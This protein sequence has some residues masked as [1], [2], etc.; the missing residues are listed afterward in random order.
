MSIRT[1][2]W[3]G[4]IPC[5]ADLSV[6]D[7][8]AAQAFYTAVLGWTFLD[9]GADF[10]GYT[11]A[12]V[13]GAAAAGVGPVQPGGS[14]AWT[15]YFASDD[16]ESTAARIGESGGTVLLPPG[17]VGGL[18]RLLIATDP[19]G[20]VFGAWQALSHIGAGVVNQPGGM[21]W[22]DL[23]TT[24]PDTARTFYRAVFGYDYAAVPMSP[25]ATTPPSRRPATRHRWAA[26]VR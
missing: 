16:L 1:S 6:P 13:D 9:P 20:A 8:E 14:P 23:R 10:G 17:E 25:E 22:E 11:I 18:G 7:V 2:P 3:P 19:T 26:W 5:W 24:D 15:L 4:S 21:T 12:Q